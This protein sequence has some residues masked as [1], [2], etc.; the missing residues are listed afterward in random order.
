MLLFWLIIFVM[1]MFALASILVPFCRTS[2]QPTNSML[3]KNLRFGTIVFLLLILPTLAIV[4]YFWWGSSSSLS[5]L[6]TAQKQAIAA[7]K[8][9]NAMGTPQQVIEV[10]KKHLDQDPYS[11]E[12]WYLLGRLYLSQQQFDK[13]V[14]AFASANDLQPNKPTILFQ[15]AQALY[16]KQQSLKGKPTELLL[17]VLRLD[18]KN[19]L[20]INLLAVAAFQIGNFQQA[21]DYWERLLPKYAPQSPDGQALLQAIAKAQSALGKK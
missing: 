12:G 13:A 19:D 21:I 18:P 15:Y 1:V 6:Y 20:A 11:A 16:F 7:Q 5:A 2:L 17:E 3:S 9:R 4:F 14:A 10:L 8:F